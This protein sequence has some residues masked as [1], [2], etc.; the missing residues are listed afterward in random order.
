MQQWLPPALIEFVRDVRQ[1]ADR[2]T[3]FQYFWK[4]F[5]KSSIPSELREMVAAFVESPDFPK[6]SRYWHYLNANNLEMIAKSGSENYRK[7][8]SLNYYTWTDF[9]E[10]LAGGLFQAAAQSP[11]STYSKLFRQ[12]PGMELVPS[13][14]HNILLVALHAAV[15]ARP[16]AHRIG[17]VREQVSD[18]TPHLRIGDIRITQDRLNSLLEFER[19]S[20]LG[21]FSGWRTVL[22]IG[23]GNGRTAACLMSLVPGLKYV[24]AD[25]PPALFLSLG[26]LRG[27]FPERRVAVG[28]KATDREQLAALIRD[29]DLIFIFPNQIRLMGDKSV[30]LFLAVDCLHE[31][32]RT[33]IDDYFSQIDRLALNFYMKVWNRT[34]VPFD[35]HHLTRDDYP[36]RQHWE[37]IF[38]VACVFPSNFSEMGY[39]L[40]CAVSSTT[41]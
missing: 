12:Q 5:D 16:I 19:I 25:I 8:V 32:T 6:I 11:N 27:L 28:F 23:A 17:E 36:A 40:P 35:L 3:D 29:N 10:E 33:T 1:R 37:K 7:D 13:V 34:R 20:L 38:D 24:I 22:E 9:S 26:N 21:D 18:S 31:M 14:K 15:M 2:R 4:R 39:S 41:A 30:D